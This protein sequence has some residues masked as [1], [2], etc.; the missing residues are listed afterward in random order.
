M[1]AFFEESV[2][3]GAPTKAVANWI[4]GDFSRL[5][6]ADRKEIEQSSIKPTHLQQLI[7]LIDSGAISG[8]MAKETF[9]AMYRDADP[10]PALTALKGSTQISGDAELETIADQVIAENAQSVSDFKAG[11][12]RALKFLIGQGMKISKGRANPQRLEALLK[13]KIK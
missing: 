7:G 11:K 3:L 4:L 9:E 10:G 5:L 6:N 13:A 2:R 1:A 12:E 8:K